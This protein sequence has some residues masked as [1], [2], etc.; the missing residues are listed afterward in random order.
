MLFENPYLEPDLLHNNGLYSTT[1][2][3]NIYH[4]DRSY[5]VRR[6]TSEDENRNA[7][8]QKLRTEIFV[9]L[10]DWSIPVDHQG[11][12]KD[13]YDTGLSSAVTIHGVYDY[14][15]QQQKYSLLGGIRIHEITTWSETMLWNEFQQANML[16]PDIRRKIQAKYDP[17]LT[18]ELT[19]FCTRKS[20]GRGKA[21]DL[22]VARDYT[23]ASVYAYAERLGRPYALALVHRPYFLV[24]KRL[25]FIFETLYT[26]FEACNKTEKYA[27]VMIHLPETIRSFHAFQQETR[28][29]RMMALCSRQSWMYN[30]KEE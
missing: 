28:A 29:Y 4:A 2:Y 16:P 20:A 18:L 14:D 5:Q 24:L 23:Y 13:Q 6:L 27:I 21:F 26:H 8:Y 25:H 19:R 12:E 22:S 30:F 10:L 15:S 9:N 1:G 7:E 11:R 17:L 3:A